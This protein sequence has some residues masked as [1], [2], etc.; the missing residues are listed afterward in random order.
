MDRTLNYT[1]HFGKVRVLHKTFLL[2]ISI[3]V[4]PQSE[5]ISALISHKSYFKISHFR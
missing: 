3:L 1:N 5:I 4:G 2:F